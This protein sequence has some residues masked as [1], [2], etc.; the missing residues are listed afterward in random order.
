[1]GAPFLPQPRDNWEE[2]SWWR[3]EGDCVWKVVRKSV[4]EKPESGNSAV[5]GA[6]PGGVNKSK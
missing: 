3:V 5:F 4:S 1:M 2:R 6:G